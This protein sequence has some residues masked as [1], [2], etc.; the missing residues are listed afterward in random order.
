MALCSER[1]AVLASQPPV[2]PLQVCPASLI[3]ASQ[4]YAWLHMRVW[5]AQSLAPEPL[6]LYV[7]PTTT[8]TVYIPLNAGP[9]LVQERGGQCHDGPWAPGEIRIARAGQARAWYVEGGFQTI[10]IDLATDF[11]QYAASVEHTP[12]AD[13]VELL[14]VFGTQDREIEYI[15]K[16]LLLE[17]DM[18]DRGGALVLEELAIR[19]ATRLRES[20]CVQAA[21]KHLYAGGLR[22]AQLQTIHDYIQAHLAAPLTLRDLADLVQLSPRHLIRALHRSTGFTPY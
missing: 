6:E 5:L 13:S 4:S 11:L 20:Y 22:P 16:R 18:E 9:R 15:G 12:S 2:D 19:L 10:H 8:H 3:T 21:E 1:M 17:L 14:D 7:P